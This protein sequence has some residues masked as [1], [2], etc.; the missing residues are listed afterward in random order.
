MSVSLITER[1]ANSIGAGELLPMVD[2]KEFK[3][4][5]TMADLLRPWQEMFPCLDVNEEGDIVSPFDW[6]SIR[7]PAF[8]PQVRRSFRP[9]PAPRPIA[10]RPQP[11]CKPGLFMSIQAIWEFYQEQGQDDPKL[12]NCPFSDDNVQA[13]V[14]PLYLKA[15]DY[16]PLN[17]PLEELYFDCGA[18][19]LLGIHLMIPHYVY[20]DEAAGVVEAFL[21]GPGTLASHLHYLHKGAN[22]EI[23]EK[24]QSLIQE[25]GFDKLT[26]NFANYNGKKSCDLIALE[27]WFETFFS[28]VERKFPEH[29][30]GNYPII[31][32]NGGMDA[33]ICI[34]SKA[35]LDFC[36]AYADAY[37]EM[38]NSFPEPTAFEYNEEGEAETFV[39][40]LCEVWRK[41]NGKRSV[42]WVT[43]KKQTL[44]ARH[45]RGEL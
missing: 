27:N 3:P 2:A 31:S 29:G 24:D 10:S 25:V 16:W 9:L 15:C 1:I 17:A 12:I 38:L 18:A 6:F 33:D 5:E 34:R 7:R 26:E 23:P 22:W 35:D 11:P 41:V 20:D 37:Y 4:V 8:R 32:G 45:K 44:L 13:F 42:K 28:E 39:H 40:E 30:A 19:E 21:S 43:P 14:H 36:F